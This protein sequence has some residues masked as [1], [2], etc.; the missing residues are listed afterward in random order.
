[1]ARKKIVWG[2]DILEAIIRV[3]R[4]AELLIIEIPVKTIAE[5]RTLADRYCAACDD[6]TGTC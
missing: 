3:N 6:A 4:P 5:A 1:M 2:D